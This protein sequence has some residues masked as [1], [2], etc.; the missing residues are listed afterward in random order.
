MCVLCVCVHMC[1][2]MCVVYV[3]ERDNMH[4]VVRGHL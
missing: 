3:Y 1:G 2:C 4:V